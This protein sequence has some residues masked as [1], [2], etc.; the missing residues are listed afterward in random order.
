MKISSHISLTGPHLSV[1]G[2]FFFVYIL[3]EEK[4]SLF[5]FPNRGI[6]RG[7]LRSILIAI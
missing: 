7:E 2:D 1:D 6:L 3:M 4:T 5:P